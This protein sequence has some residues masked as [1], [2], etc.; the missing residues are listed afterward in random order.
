M[1]NFFPCAIIHNVEDPVPFIW[2]YSPIL[3]E[4]GMVCT[5]RYT[6]AH[7]RWATDMREVAAHPAFTFS[8]KN[9]EIFF[10][11]KNTMKTTKFSVGRVLVA[12]LLALVMAFS[13]VACQDDTPDRLA[14]L[15][16]AK[17][18]LTKA[19]ADVKTV[20]DAAATKTALDAAQAAIAALQ[21]GSATKEELKAATD[22]LAEVEEDLALV[23][24][25]AEV[26]AI[27]T[28][29]EATINTAK[30]ALE[31][32][33]AE[34][35]TAIA[36]LK[37]SAD[38]VAGLIDTKV[39]ALKTE[40][41][42]KITALET[43]TTNLQNAI[44]E[45]DGKVDTHKAEFDELKAA[46][47]AL[48]ATVGSLGDENGEGLVNFVEGYKAA[49]KL[50][51]EV[52]E[53]GTPGEYSFAA[54][55]ELFNSIKA[56][57]YE[58]ATYKK[59][60]ASHDEL[61]FYLSRATSVQDVKDIFA[62]L[63]A[64]IADLPTLAETLADKIEKI[65]YLKADEPTA[66][67]IASIKTV[68]GKMET[69]G[70][71]IEADLKADYDALLA[72][73]DNL[74]AAD[75]YLKN[76][77]AANVDALPAVVLL[78]TSKDVV[79]AIKA[80]FA[81]FVST[82]F[83]DNAVNAYYY[84]VPADDAE[85]T[86]EEN[87]AA[88]ADAA[89]AY[90][91][92]L[93]GEDY[94]TAKAKID[95]YAALD[96]LRGTMVLNDYTA[97]GVTML[98]LYSDSAITDHYAT[99]DAWLDANDL[100]DELELETPVTHN[101]YT[102]LGEDK[103]VALDKANTYVKAM[104]EI[105]TSMVKG[106]S[107]D[108]IKD[109]NDIVAVPV[110]TLTA[111]EQNAKD[112][113][114]D[115]DAVE[116]AIDAVIGAYDP[117]LDSNFAKMLEAA[118]T[119]E[120][121]AQVELRMT[122]L[123]AAKLA[124]ADLL[125]QIKADVPE[126][127]VVYSDYKEISAHI[128]TSKNYKTNYALAEVHYTEV[129]ATAVDELLAQLV[130]DYNV[131]IADIK[132][133][134]IETKKLLDQLNA[135]TLL[136]SQGDDILDLYDALYEIVVTK[137]VDNIDIALGE[138]DSEEA[139]LNDLYV[140]FA[141]V[142]TA[143]GEMAEEAED[144]AQAVINLMLSEWGT[145]A[146]PDADGNYDTD[147]LEGFAA[148]LQNVE[149]IDEV[150]AAFN[151]WYGEYLGNEVGEA[152]AVLAAIDNIEKYGQSGTTYDFIDFTEWF[153][154]IVMDYES[155]AA[156]D[157]AAAERAAISA[158]LDAFRA[159]GAIDDKLVTVP[160]NDDVKAIVEALTK[161]YK[162][163]WN[164]DFVINDVDTGAL[165]SATYEALAK[166]AHSTVALATVEADGM[167]KDA[168]QVVV[169]SEYKLAKAQAD[170]DD[171]KVLI[172]AIMALDPT[173]DYD[174]IIA[175]TPAILDAL[176]VFYNNYYNGKADNSLFS[177]ADDETTTDIDETVD[178]NEYILDFHKKDKQADMYKVYA[179][180]AVQLLTDAERNELNAFI[181]LALR[182][183]NDAKTVAE[184]EAACSAGS[185][186]A[187]SYLSKVMQGYGA[188]EW[189]YV[190]DGAELLDAL[191]NAKAGAWIILAANTDFAAVDASGLNLS[192]NL[193]V[194]G[195]EAVT[196]AGMNLPAIN[197][198][199]L[200]NITFTAP[201]AAV[202]VDVTNL[203]VDACTF[204][205]A[206]LELNSYKAGT[207]D[208]TF[209]NIIVKNSKFDGT[210]LAANKTAVYLGGNVVGA[211]VTGNEI[212]DSAFNAVQM[213]AN[214]SGKIVITDNKITNTGDRVF[215]FGTLTTGALVEIKKNTIVSNGDTTEGGTLLKF[216]TA[217]AAD[218]IVT[219]AENTWNGLADA[220]VADKFINAVY[221]APVAP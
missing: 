114:E 219:I 34:F 51:Y 84:A 182:Q 206:N 36:N 140:G 53:D 56:A 76:N 16:Q 86:D 112:I 94:T 124:Y 120:F 204:E 209:T 221:V 160:A 22:K 78:D 215:R 75:N 93:A 192:A 143:Y 72:A 17:A 24:T 208:K 60:A 187:T 110:L 189:R 55:E 6:A 144:A 136:L 126:L 168:V 26:A 77:Y 213:P 46:V 98:P 174:A 188:T 68:Y 181:P 205:G 38:G 218:G 129:G 178:G 54:F 139:N 137:G 149:A 142:V 100:D 44:E 69:Q 29:L 207:Y 121:E 48:Q 57:D 31:A 147:A 9:F 50:L 80:E 210:G 79:D 41:E 175:N 119:A 159:N 167:T 13:F 203:T 89:E 85:A 7:F 108:L 201:V 195:Q 152:S 197:G 158:M 183:F 217:P 202:Y 172:D 63:K 70:V 173:V 154:I 71:E 28:A 91:I 95:R 1:T 18:D 61:K 177:V 43:S 11:R 64:A 33:D 115:I 148:L 45:L 39:A 212:V 211:T 123:N 107:V 97:F 125:A 133:V 117:A 165:F 10:E 166:Y 198:L 62:D 199:T 25:D 216:T 92:T 131:L 194:I 179:D 8:Q 23:A 171:I 3:E 14:A 145:I 118:K 15:E 104:N 127:K 4:G 191:K 12:L 155:E 180:I 65:G 87:A 128:E 111:N 59:Y 66:E 150:L 141:K 67:K 88:K 47:E 19:L 49:T 42:G 146:V 73:Y 157:A 96:A 58:D 151:A 196:V 2:G 37:T 103:F 106:E 101:V 220:D 170:R 162:T 40:L 193:T 90:A 81:T 153:L 82:Y 184:V 185:S 21:T 74:L 105:Y 35:A 113:R 109:I 122:Q 83:A 134:Y 200:K 176:E 214:V 20:A 116:A 102:L 30:A 99:V 156:Q 190:T 163:F 138:V 135:G 27:K 130:A 164:D 32:K 161:Y 5:S 52:K 186:Y 132:A 169:I